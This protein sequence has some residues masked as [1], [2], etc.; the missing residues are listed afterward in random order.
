VWVSHNVTITPGCKHIGRGAVI[1]AGAVVTKDVPAYAIV[2]G[3]P[4]SVVRYRFEPETQA[5]IEA[6]RWWE[7]SKAELRDLVRRAPD[8]VMRPTAAKLAEL[9]MAKPAP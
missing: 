9:G 8:T 2:V 5:A 4:A 6:S 7:L 3:M 1:G